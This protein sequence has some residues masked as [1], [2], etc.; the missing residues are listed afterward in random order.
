MYASSHTQA[1]RTRTMATIASAANTAI[2]PRSRTSGLGQLQHDGRG[3]I[4]G[5]GAGA[6]ILDRAH[7]PV[8]DL[9][10]RQVPRLSHELD[11][12]RTAELL[13]VWIH[14]LGHAVRREHEHVVY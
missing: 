13:A 11:E 9:F 2:R 6:V 1:V 10:R 4:V 5:G 8:D 7:D 14:R 12:P 3:V